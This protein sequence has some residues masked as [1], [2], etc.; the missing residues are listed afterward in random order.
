M[1]GSPG[2]SPF[3]FESLPLDTSAPGSFFPSHPGSG[4]PGLSLVSY[5]LWKSCDRL[6]AVTGRVLPS[7]MKSVVKGIS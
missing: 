3:W 4:M 6:S 5:S 1:V 2:G 7:S